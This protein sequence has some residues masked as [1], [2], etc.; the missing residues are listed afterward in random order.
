MEA[1]STLQQAIIHFSDFENCKRFMVELRW[2]DGLIACPRCGATKVTWLEKPRVWKCYAKHEKPTFTLKTGT[3]FEDSP[4]PLEKWLPAVWLIAGCKNGVSSYEVH[5]DLDVTQKT[6]WFMLHRIR[7]A[8]Q[9][10]SFLKLSGDVEADET[11][12]GG[13]IGNM[14]KKTRTRKINREGRIGGGGTEGKAFVVGML[15]RGGDVEAPAARRAEGVDG[16]REAADGRAQGDIVH[17]LVRRLGE[18]AM[19]ERRLAVADR[20][21]DDRV[22]VAH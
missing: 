20:I 11:F 13:K 15:E 17:R 8:M 5:R 18:D 22:M 19:D 14:N 10:D 12:I 1:A 2:P 16:V 6:A 3:I 4:I 7:L 21:A 9:S